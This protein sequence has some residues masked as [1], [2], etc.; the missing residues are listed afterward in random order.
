MKNKLF[1][2]LLGAILN[3]T[4]FFSVKATGQTSFCRD[5]VLNAAREII[6]ET[7]HC[8]LITTDS[9]GLPHVR[10]MSH[11]PFTPDFVIWFATARNSMKVTEIR[12]NPKVCVYFSD[13]TK[14]DGYVAVIGKAEIIDDKALLLSKK[15]DYWD[16]I[17]R[18]KEIFVLIKI[19]PKKLEVI[20]Y[21]RGVNSDPETLKAPSVEF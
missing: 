15:R 16:G 14:A 2:F 12:H 9:T 3:F 7:D 13:H 20:N 10:T 19:V 21:P 1:L 6:N 17:P 11:F 8:A 18:W 4:F 5:S